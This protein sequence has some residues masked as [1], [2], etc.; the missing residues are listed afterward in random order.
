MAL[1]DLSFLAPHDLS[2]AVVTVDSSSLGSLSGL[3]GN[4][5]MGGVSLMI[6][7]GLED[8]SELRDVIEFSRGFYLEETS[9][10]SLDGLQN[11]ESMVG[12]GITSSPIR[13]VTEL[14]SLRHVSELTL[15]GLR[16]VSRVDLSGIQSLDS[17]VILGLPNVNEILLPD[18]DAL[19]QASISNN[20][21][22]QC[23]IDDW[24]DSMGNPPVAPFRNVFDN[25]PCD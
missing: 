14:R 3:E 23:V 21:V 22:S 4:P 16:D 2:D 12:L 24:L 8:L 17:L 1:K 6:V 15:N 25:G 18:L 9:V 19:E 20:S 13:R 10:R 11:L 7:D 5:K